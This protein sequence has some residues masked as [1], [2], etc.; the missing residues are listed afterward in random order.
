MQRAK[1]DPGVEKFLEYFYKS[2]I[3]TLYKPFGDIPEFRQLQ[4]KILFTAFTAP[5]NYCEKN[6]HFPFRRNEQICSSI[7]AICCAI[8]P[9][10]IPSAV[11]SSFFRP[12]SLPELPP[13]FPPEINIYA[14]VC[15]I[16]PP[17]PLTL[18]EYFTAAF[19]FFRICLRI[20]N[21]NL[22]NH[23]IKLDILQPII[24]LSIKESGRDNLISSSCQE[25]FDHMRKVCQ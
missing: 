7:S 17:L 4:S 20:N 21:R 11:I 14:W 5:T 22:F 9:F 13:F 15:F 12:I 1:D 19:R 10:S 8:L 24:D 25:F 6:P 16:G 3:D 23:L 18:I 2:C